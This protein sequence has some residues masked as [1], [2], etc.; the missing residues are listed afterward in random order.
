[1]LLVVFFFIS[2]G[3]N[4]SWYVKI[5]RQ[6]LDFKGNSKFKDFGFGY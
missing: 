6:K 4:K 2:R 3:V 5:I 1:M